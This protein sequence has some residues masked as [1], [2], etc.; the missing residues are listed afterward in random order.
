MYNGAGCEAVNMRSLSAGRAVS[1]SRRSCGGAREVQLGDP[2]RRA[3]TARAA[4][5]R[6]SGH[7]SAVGAKE[8]AIA[9][10]VAGSGVGGSIVLQQ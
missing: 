5:R 7:S 3:S 4:G 6:D 8:R 2:E 9:G 10:S 1:G